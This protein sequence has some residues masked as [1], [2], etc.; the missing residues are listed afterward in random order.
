[1]FRDNEIYVPNIGNVSNSET[2]PKLHLGN[3]DAYRDW[4]H[5]E[6]YVRA[7]WMVVQQDVPD[8]YVIATG[9]TYSVRNFLERAF[10][11]IGISDFT[12]YI[13]I[14]PKFYRPS[15]V[16]FLRGRPTKAMDTLGWKPEVSFDEL[17]HRMVWGDINGSE[18]QEKKAC[19]SKEKGC[20]K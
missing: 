20:C 19:C 9:N 8:D 2:F 13:V 7:M 1:V 14:D 16:E 12:P 18:T 17:V 4:G 3:L 15:E 6:D 11:E 5:A 10:N